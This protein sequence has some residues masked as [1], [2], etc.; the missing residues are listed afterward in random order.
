[1]PLLGRGRVCLGEGLPKASYLLY[2]VG[3]GIPLSH[4]LQAVHHEHIVELVVLNRTCKLSLA[5]RVRV[6]VARSP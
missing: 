2:H 5:S 6:G 4:K 1:M 3:L